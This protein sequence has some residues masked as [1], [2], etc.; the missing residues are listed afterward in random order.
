M[1]LFAKPGLERELD[2]PRD[3]SEN[4]KLC[5]D[6]PKI[7]IRGVFTKYPE[8]TNTKYSALRWVDSFF[9]KYVL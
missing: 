5:G 8:D 4:S 9:I 1:V 7:F 6:S 2:G 3:P